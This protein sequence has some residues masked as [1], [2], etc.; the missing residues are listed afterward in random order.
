MII[1]FYC[2]LFIIKLRKNAIFYT[3]LYRNQSLPCFL[4]IIAIYKI[5][6]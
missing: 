6:I 5:C 3:Y 2:V 4:A 1:S